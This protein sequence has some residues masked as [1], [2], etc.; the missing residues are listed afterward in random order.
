LDS[1]N[2]D[3]DSEN[4]EQGGLWLAVG[5]IQLAL[6]ES[7]VLGKSSLRGGFRYCSLCLLEF[8]ATHWHLMMLPGI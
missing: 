2:Q 3:L 4:H 1:E 5:S 6:H 7:G 8:N